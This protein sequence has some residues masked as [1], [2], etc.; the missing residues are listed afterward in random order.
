GDLHAGNFRALGRSDRKGSS[1]VLPRL[2]SRVDPLAQLADERGSN[3]RVRLGG[4]AGEC[5]SPQPAVPHSDAMGGDYHGCG[6]AAAA[7]F[8]AVWN[9]DHRSGG[10]AADRDHQRVLLHRAF[11]S[12]ADATKFSGNGAGTDYA[13]LSSIRGFI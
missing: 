6:R 4:G 10:V 8:A 7:G 5:G 2:V 3:W 1:P 11:R 9:A 12:A 13:A